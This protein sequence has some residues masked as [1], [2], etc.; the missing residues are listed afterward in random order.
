MNY[1]ID[2]DNTLYD[3][4]K[5]AEK[6][7]RC[8]AEKNAEISNDSIESKYI[9]CKAMF[10]RENIYD[11]YELAKYF[12]HQYGYGA[13]ILINEINNKILSSK[14]L[15]FEDVI[16]FLTKLKE[17]GNKLYMLTYCAGSIEFQSIK[18]AGSKIADYFDALY[19]T[20]EPKYNLDI[21]YKNG[22]F[23]DDNP[24]DLIGLYQKE[25]KEVI[26]IRREG[27]KYSIE[28]IENI[29]IKEYK[30]FE[31]IKNI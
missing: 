29:N 21:D 1:Y 2:F 13:D 19:I 9:E 27:N 18:I 12:S 26:R 20:K 23:I 31:E 11:I 6:M 7:L 10:N 30:N 28:D 15:I 8:I 4:P 22:I 16:P 5:L 25:A 14:E 24:K 3:T 17:K